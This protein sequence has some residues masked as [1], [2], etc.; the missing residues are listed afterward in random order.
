MVELGLPL[1][2]HI[3]CYN[4]GS[5]DLSKDPRMHKRSKHIDVHY[6]FIREKIDEDKVTVSYVP[7]EENTADI[8]T[9]ALTKTKFLSFCAQ[10]RCIE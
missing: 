8:F 2:P 7:S 9:K 5:L 3:F 4:Q 10:L 6:H 1:V